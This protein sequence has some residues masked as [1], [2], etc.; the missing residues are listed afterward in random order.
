VRLLSPADASL[1]AEHYGI[2]G[3]PS[4]SQIQLF[5]SEK[6]ALREVLP[7]SSDFEARIRKFDARVRLA[8]KLAALTG[9]K[10]S[11]SGI[12]AKA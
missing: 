1:I 3:A 4:K 12:P 11:K 5:F 7:L 6:L 2:V 10:K 9:S 8:L